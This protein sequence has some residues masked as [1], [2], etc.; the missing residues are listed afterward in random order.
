[1][2]MTQTDAILCAFRAGERLTGEDARRRFGCTRLPA[3]VWELR[4]AGHPVADRMVEVPTRYGTTH[5]SEYWLP[6]AGEL[7]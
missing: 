1:M 7:F 4:E 6:R 5:V 2:T 3:R